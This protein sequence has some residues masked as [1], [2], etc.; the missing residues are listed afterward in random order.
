MY[1]KMA[2]MQLFIGQAAILATE[3]D[4]HLVLRCFRPHPVSTFTRGQ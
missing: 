2:F 4:S 3:D 1:V